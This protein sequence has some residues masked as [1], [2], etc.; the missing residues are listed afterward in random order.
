MKKSYIQP[1]IEVIANQA[2]NILAGSGNVEVKEYTDTPNQY[3][4]DQK[5]KGGDG[6][7]FAKQSSWG[8]WDE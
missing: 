1:T 7:D 4:I 8:S 3:D 2:A 5:L 6:T